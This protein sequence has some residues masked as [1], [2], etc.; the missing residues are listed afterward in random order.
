M[1]LFNIPSIMLRSDKHNNILAPKF[2]K[3]KNGQF[4]IDFQLGTGMGIALG[5]GVGGVSMWLSQNGDPSRS[6]NLDPESCESPAKDLKICPG[7]SSKER[8]SSRQKWK[9][10]SRLVVMRPW[11]CS[12]PGLTRPR[13]CHRRCSRACDSARTSW[14]VEGVPPTE[15]CAPCRRGLKGCSLS[16]PSCGSNTRKEV[17]RIVIAGV[18]EMPECARQIGTVDRL[19]CGTGDSLEMKKDQIP[20]D[21]CNRWQPLRP[22][23]GFVSGMPASGRGSR[24]CR[25]TSCRG[26]WS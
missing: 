18:P 5:E 20:Q 8:S 12:W 15:H 9:T 3:Y 1:S 25:R 22:L 21:I 19:V 17:H 2:N 11:R 4:R 23:R 6:Q 14:A 26:P 16:W 24:T 13:K 10:M 7:S